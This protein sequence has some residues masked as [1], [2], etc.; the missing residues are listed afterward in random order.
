MDQRS[1][2]DLLALIGARNITLAARRRNISQPAYS[3]RLQTIEATYETPLVD[4]T[5][6]PA[7]PTPALDNM[8]REIK[9]ALKGLKDLGKSFSQNSS[10]IEKTI[11]I[12]ALHSLASGPVPTAISRIAHLLSSHRIRLRAANQDVCF[13]F[14][15][16]EEVSVM[17]AYET[18]DKI[19]QA[20]TDLVKKTYVASDRMVAVCS[21]E[22]SQ[23]IPDMMFSKKLIPLVAYPESVFLGEV[24]RDNILPL[25]PH[26]FSKRLIAGL[27]GTLI[28]SV[29]AGMGM[30]WLPISSIRDELENRKLIIVEGLGFPEMDLTISML[31]LRTKDMQKLAPL[32]IALSQSVNDV[33][34]N[35][36]P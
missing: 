17:F 13:Q 20:P 25:S 10:E 14:L 29:S 6:R 8:H 24:L 11:S 28:S 7:T 27:T 3:R 1:L 31:Q 12:A 23:K 21:P 9:A 32:C 2:E 15:M 34:K 4:R 22:L 18:I 26:H 16:T 35:P 33:I 30:A 19:L 5:K 36:S